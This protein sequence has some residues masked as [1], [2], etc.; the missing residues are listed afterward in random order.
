MTRLSYGRVFRVFCLESQKIDGTYERYNHYFRQILFI[1]YK[2]IEY[3][4]PSIF[5]T[6]GRKHGRN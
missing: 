4:V 3:S 2:Y 6:Q 1:I 5:E